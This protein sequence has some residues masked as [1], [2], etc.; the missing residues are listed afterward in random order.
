[1]GELGCRL[2][3]IQTGER[4]P[5]RLTPRCRLRSSLRSSLRPTLAWS[6]RL[7]TQPPR[8]GLRVRQR[9]TLY[10]MALKIGEGQ[11]RHTPRR[12]RSHT[13]PPLRLPTTGGAAWPA[14]ARAS[15]PA[16]PKPC[17]RS[18]AAPFAHGPALPPPGHRGC[19]LARPCWGQHL[20]DIPTV[21]SPQGGAFGLTGY[22]RRGREGATSH[23]TALPA[24]VGLCPPFA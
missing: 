23:N 19:G 22:G 9:E 3:V 5:R 7:L 8:P 1:V 10:E 21:C 14:P 2:E 17:P 24:P 15:F 4:T 6:R 13:V 11:G 16:S 20:P 12:L 18:P